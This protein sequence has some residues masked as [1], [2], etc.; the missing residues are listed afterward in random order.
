VLKLI[1]TL[2]FFFHTL[3]LQYVIFYL[4]IRLN[5]NFRKQKK[6]ALPI[7]VFSCHKLMDLGR[8]G[9]IARY[10]K[11]RLMFVIISYLTTDCQPLF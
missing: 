3:Y 9:R 5:L 2:P 7:A 11:Y 1:H 4:W 6:S 10:R 8:N